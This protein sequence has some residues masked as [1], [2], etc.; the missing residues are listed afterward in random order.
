MLDKISKQEAKDIAMVLIA[1]HSKQI[2]GE[3]FSDCENLIDEDEAQL[4]IDEMKK[5]TDS[6][7]KKMEKK[8]GVQLSH[9]GTTEQIIDEMLYE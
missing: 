8:Y 2:D 1:I 6:M 3:A 9:L 5:I 7:I 4:I